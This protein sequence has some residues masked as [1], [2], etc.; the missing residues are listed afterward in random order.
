LDS[1]WRANQSHKGYLNTNDCK[2]KNSNFTN[3]EPKDDMNFTKNARRRRR[4]R[5]RRRKSGAMKK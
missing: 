2:K 4:R 5:R 1:F 3:K